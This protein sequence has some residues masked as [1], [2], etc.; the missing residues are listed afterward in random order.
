MNCSGT[1][2]GWITFGANK[3]YHL[4]RVFPLLF[5]LLAGMCS[6]GQS[7]SSFYFTHYDM[8]DGLASNE[9]FDVVQDR[10][11]YLW[12]ATNNGLQRFDGVQYKTFKKQRGDAHSLP[13]NVIYKLLIDQKDNLWISA[14]NGTVGL[15][16]K[17]SFRFTHVPI[18]V[19]DSSVLTSNHRF[20]TD[21]FGNVFLI[22]RGSYI[23]HYN[24]KKKAFTPISEFIPVETSWTYTS[25]SHQPGTQKYWMGL[26]TGGVVIYNGKTK[27]VS[28]IGHNVEGEPAVEACGPKSDFAFSGFDKKGRVW[29]QSWGAGFPLCNQYDPAKGVKGLKQF[30][31]I[32]SLKSYHEYRGHVE[33]RDGRIWVFGTRLLA[34]YK[35]AEEKF[36]LLP[37]D[38]LNNTG[39]SIDAVSQLYEDRDRNLWVATQSQGLYR[40]NPSTQ[41]FS[42]FYHKARTKPGVGEGTVMSFMQTQN[43]DLLTGAWEDGLFRYNSQLK[44][45][46]LGFKDSSKFGMPYVWSMCS[47]RNGKTIWMGAQPGVYAYNQGNNTWAFRNPAPLANYTVRQ[48]AED[49][50]GNLW[51][52][53][54]GRGIFYWTD[55]FQTANDSVLQI[56]EAGN[57]MVNRILVDRTNTVWVATGDKGVLVLDGN[58]GRLKK[59][60][61][62][63]SS[64]Q[65]DVIG[66]AVMGF[67][68]YSDS[69][70]IVAGITQLY[71][72]NRQTQ[73]LREWLLP[74]GF[75]GNVAALE[76]DGSGHVWVSTTNGLYRLHP[77]KKT[78][79]IYNRNDGMGS[80]RFVLSG[81]YKLRD[82]RLVFAAEN[83]F[84]VFDPKILSASEPAT[85]VVITGIQVGRNDLRVDSIVALNGLVLPARDNYVSIN[86]STLHYVNDHRI[87]YK[88]EGIDDDW[89][90]AER[91][92]R[93][94][95]PYLPVGQHTLLLRSVNAEGEFS[96]TTRLS[97][98]IKP[99][100]Y[101]TW[102]FYTLIAIGFI[103]ELWWLDRQRSL[104][105]KGLQKVR[106]DIS[107]NL[108]QEV[109][110]ALNNIN[111][112]SEIAR[113]KSDKEPEKAKEYLEQI[114][115]KS[116]NMIIAMDDM[117]WSLDPENDSMDK[118]ISRVKEYAD[119]L[120][121]RHDVVIELGI[122]K[123]V[124]KLVL[125]MKL[126]HEA[127]L[128]FKEG[129]RNIVEAGTGYCI[130]HLAT[131]GAKL[132]FAIEFENDGCDMQKLNNLL[133]RRDMGIR[134]QA[135]GAKLDVQLHKSRSQFLLQLPLTN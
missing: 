81:S 85:P 65:G 18:R 132:L 40:F 48:V 54:H 42:N 107:D 56:A 10:T 58:T 47:S 36:E 45:T 115:N 69:L 15:F 6:A 100:W 14:N 121:Q 102:W 25:F 24:E 7:P 123:K 131:E 116:H 5:F 19:S 52:G 16:D 101:Q 96:N 49:E 59:H 77:K 68:D 128:L 22:L 103:A 29:F 27:N 62:K 8:Q 37:T 3:P 80:D 111:I 72:W 89:R 92:N 46:P 119:A 13:A 113:L 73:T 17:N 11:G 43:G 34:Y 112:L 50:K 41:H 26:Q 79:V 64:A 57:A 9:V 60:W 4:L 67:V 31:F 98:Q 39:L 129:L 53:M 76:T 125:N 74:E 82:G 120:M 134:L 90:V 63:G 118:T 70:L 28:Y 135:L 21:E 1:G 99:P 117:L 30:E 61:I 126:R 130:V 95:Y 55:P 91:S 44:N 35:E 105:K 86:I 23:F 114:H 33:Q 133:Q 108:H 84:T 94:S 38:N 127:F 75:L 93:I 83:S 20:T 110:E 12:I 51:L 87:V 71:F 109:N 2:S 78:M 124:E 97:I 66:N 104:R 32:S 88:M 106:T 122:D